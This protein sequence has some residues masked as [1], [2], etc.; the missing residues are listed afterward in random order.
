MKATIVE[1][2]FYRLHCSPLYINMAF[3]LESVG[4]NGVLKKFLNIILSS[5]NLACW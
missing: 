2:F 3:G 5:Q 1:E 4:D